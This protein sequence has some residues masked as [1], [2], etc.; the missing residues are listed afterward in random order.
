MR[1]P[2]VAVAFQ[3]RQGQ[4]AAPGLREAARMAD[5][6]VKEANEVTRALPDEAVRDR[7]V[8]L[9]FGGDRQRF[10][11]FLQAIHDALPFPVTVVLRG[12]AVTGVKWA[13]GSPFDAKGPGT[14]DLDLTFVGGDMLKLYDAF[15]IPGLHSMPLSD[16][17]PD[18]APALVPLR[19]AL[20][21]LAGRPVNIQATSSLVQYARDVLLD[22]PYH[23]L[24]DADEA[25]DPPPSD[26]SPS[27]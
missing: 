15:H 20:S 8:R 3:P 16:D 2:Q 26:A 5:D 4:V 21:A 27:S 17:T 7:V 13:D 12:S 9:A 11:Q 22:Q 1:I 24:I 25:A 10:E 6:E 23:T 14:S 19:R 18:A